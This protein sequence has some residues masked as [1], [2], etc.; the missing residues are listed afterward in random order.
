MKA[1]DSGNVCHESVYERLFRNLAPMLRNF[2]LYKFRDQEA[3]EDAV[4]E[5]FITLWNNCKNVTEGLAKAY[6]FKVGQNQMLKKVEKEKVHAR[7][8]GLQSSDQEAS[9]PD[10]DLEYQE[11]H[12]N[13]KT[14]IEQLPEGQ[15]EV[16]LLNRIDGKTYVEIAE[17]LEVSVKAIEKRMH[18]ALLKL[19]E[20][21]VNI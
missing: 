8:I 7:Y 15:R 9:G 14:A 13:L 3:A 1:V 5:A 6:V 11:I 4:Q 10:F 19:R 20:I 12:N 17:L 16:F 21:C 18:K 2:L